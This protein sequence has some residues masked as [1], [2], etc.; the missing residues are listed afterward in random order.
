[1][2]EAGNH[3][4]TMGTSC[5]DRI[6]IGRRRRLQWKF[7]HRTR[8]TPQHADAD[9]GRTNADAD[10]DPPNADADNHAQSHADADADPPNADADNHAQSHADATPQR[11]RGP[12]LDGCGPLQ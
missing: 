4:E 5:P 3:A 11:E 7:A 2:D 10:A 12:H 9:A 1:V 8:H 6:R